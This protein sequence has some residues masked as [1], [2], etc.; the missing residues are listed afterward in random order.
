MANSLNLLKSNLI[1]EFMPT[2]IV[3]FFLQ[4][5]GFGYIRVPESRE[6]FYVHKRELRQP[7]ARGMQV[8]FEIREDKHGPY[9]A[10]VVACGA[11][12]QAEK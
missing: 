8:Q 10:A 12:D 6:E 4:D 5:K 2:G 3:Q 7:V 1:P 11:P 9:A